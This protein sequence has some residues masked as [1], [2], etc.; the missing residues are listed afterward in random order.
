MT[1]DEHRRLTDTVRRALDRTVA[2]L[3]DVTLKHL[4][5]ARERALDAARAGTGTHRLPRH[6]LHGPLGAAVAV[7]LVAAVGAW[8][9]LSLP[10]DS[11]PTP[12]AALDDLEL[13]AQQEAP[14]FYADLEFYRWLASHRQAG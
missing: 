8:L 2:Q 1:D 6:R 11:G 5:A 4:R 3:D 10:A 9:W 12:V 7:T 13:L 14:D